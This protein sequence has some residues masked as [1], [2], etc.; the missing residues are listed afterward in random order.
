MFELCFLFVHTASCPSL[1]IPFG[2]IEGQFERGSN[3]TVFCNPGYTLVGV[4]V[5]Y[6]DQYGKWIGNAPKCLR[7]WQ[8]KLMLLMFLHLQCVCMEIFAGCNLVICESAHENENES[9]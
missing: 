7:E 2:S 6:C 1:D 9:A 4:K 8:S 5:L 3:V